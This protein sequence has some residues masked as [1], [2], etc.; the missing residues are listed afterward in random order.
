MICIT[1]FYKHARCLQPTANIFKTLLPCFLMSRSSLAKPLTIAPKYAGMIIERI[2]LT[3]F[4]TGA[5]VTPRVRSSIR[6]KLP[7]RIS[8]AVSHVNSNTTS[9]NVRKLFSKEAPDL[10]KDKALVDVI[11][12]GIQE[13]QPHHQ[14]TYLRY[15]LHFL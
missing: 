11:K 7:H 13:A 3:S 4:D 10:L 14:S 6:S 9:K 15:H 1:I 5:S 12:S 2:R 8:S